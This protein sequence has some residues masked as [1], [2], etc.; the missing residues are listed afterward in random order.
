MTDYSHRIPPQDL[1]AEKSILSCVLLDNNCIM[2]IL[3][4]IASKDFYRDNHRRIF[5]AM[6]EMSTQKE[7]IDLVTLVAKLRSNGELDSVGGIACVS[8]LTD[9]H[10]SANAKVYAKIVKEKSIGRELIITS[11]KISDAAYSGETPVEELLNSAQR[12]MINISLKETKSNHVHVKEIVMDVFKSMEKASEN[13]EHVSGLSTGLAEFDKMT[14][15][16]QPSDLII[17]AARPSM[18]KTSLALGI[19]DHAG[20]QDAVVLVK[21]LEMS[22][23]QL[24]LRHLTLRAEIEGRRL[25]SGFV[26]DSWWPKLTRA[27]SEIS[28]QNMIIDDSSAQTEMDIYNS[29]LKIK[30]EYGRIDLIVIDYLQL[31]RPAN[32]AENRTGEIGQ[33]TRGLKMVAKDFNCPVVALSQLNRGVESRSDKRPLLSD[34][35]ESGNIEQ[36]ADVILFIYRDEVYNNSPDSPE[37]GIAE[38]IIGKQRNGP[39]GTRKVGFNGQCTKFFNLPEYKERWDQK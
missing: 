4:V 17:I 1:D 34:L 20:E 28:K 15:G 29:A 9:F 23:E 3:E 14:G 16:L 18:G 11:Q 13:P 35:R 31:M 38:L 25:M 33:I 36:D 37:K 12:D 32:K 27:A 21:S 30:R 8:E 5:E 7:P 6:V 24:G 10:S 39:V 19:A 2:D 26:Q 22:K